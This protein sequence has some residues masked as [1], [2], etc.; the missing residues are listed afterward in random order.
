[1]ITDGVTPCDA[2]AEA[3]EEGGMVEEGVK[4]VRRLR[5][6]SFFRCIALRT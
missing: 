6:I 1:M 3:A 2:L 4:K 5:H